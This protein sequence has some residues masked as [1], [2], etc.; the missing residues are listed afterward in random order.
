MR[1][2]R[3]QYMGHPARARA[4]AGASDA[5]KEMEPWSLRS[6]SMARTTPGTPT[7]CPPAIRSANSAVGPSV[8]SHGPAAHAAPAQK[9]LGWKR[10]GASSRPSIAT[11]LFAVLRQG[12]VSDNA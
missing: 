3:C 8:Q 1:K 4:M 9:E 7:E 6:R 11:V 2:C 12:A 5:A 10:A